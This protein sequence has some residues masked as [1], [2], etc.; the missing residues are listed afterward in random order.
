MKIDVNHDACIGCGLCVNT[1]QENFDWDITGYI[2]P[3]NNHITEKTIAAKNSCPVDA[4][5]IN[6]KNIKEN[7]KS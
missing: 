2:I 5:S 1:D 7:D 3:I 4:I 6:E